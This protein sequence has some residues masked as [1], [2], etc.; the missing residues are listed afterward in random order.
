MNPV[1]PKSFEYV[2]PLAVM[3]G[4]KV[5]AVRYGGLIYILLPHF[6]AQFIFTSSQT[7]CE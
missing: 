3:V 7:I 1:L 4:F 5:T 6:V 2:E